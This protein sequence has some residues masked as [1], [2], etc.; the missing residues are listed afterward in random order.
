MDD[1]GE[2]LYLARGYAWQ[3]A[4]QDAK[5]L[6]YLAKAE[7]YTLGVSLVVQVG[8]VVPLSSF[9]TLVLGEFRPTIQHGA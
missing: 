6:D 9:C 1:I 8:Q 2:S 5:Q 4:W 7:F 3:I